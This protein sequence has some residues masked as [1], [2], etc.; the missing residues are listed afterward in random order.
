MVEIM[1][2]KY[3]SII[4]DEDTFVAT[5]DSGEQKEIWK[6]ILMGLEEAFLREIK[7]AKKNAKHSNK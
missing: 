4:L 1:D 6:Q 3:S 2:D 7:E 5:P